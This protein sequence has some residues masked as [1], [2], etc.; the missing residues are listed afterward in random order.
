MQK[1]ATM[2]YLLIVQEL[3]S[4]LRAVI[5]RLLGRLDG[6]AA[7]ER[8]E[9]DSSRTP[10]D[11]DEEWVNPWTTQ[12]R[13]LKEALALAQQRNASAKKSDSQS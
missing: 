11:L 1:E 9:P 13:L 7:R 2:F 4:F 3:A 6:I 5:A 12:Q 10:V 8:S